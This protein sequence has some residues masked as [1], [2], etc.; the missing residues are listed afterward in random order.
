MPH[1]RWPWQG[2]KKTKR[3]MRVA[4]SADLATCSFLSAEP[5]DSLATRAEIQGQQ[6]NLNGNLLFRA[7]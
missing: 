2:I 5:S 1:V 6:L 7:N 3:A 4:V